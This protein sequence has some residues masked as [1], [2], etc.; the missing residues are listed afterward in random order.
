MTDPKSA[1]DRLKRYIT[2]KLEPDLTQLGSN[3]HELLAHNHRRI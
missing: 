1:S 3:Q 2:F